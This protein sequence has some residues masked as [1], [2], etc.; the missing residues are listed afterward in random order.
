MS[1]QALMTRRPEN[2]EL[3]EIDVLAAKDEELVEISK[4]L[5]LNLSLD[6]MKSIQ[7]YFA[8]KMRKPTD[9]ELQSLGQ[10]WSEHCCYKSSKVFL[11]EHIFNIH[12][13]DVLLKGDAGVMVFAP[14]VIFGGKKIYPGTVHQVKI[15]NAIT[16]IIKGIIAS[17]S[18]IA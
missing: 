11:R 14:P 17:Q 18:A 4:A 2:F 10:A 16:I 5:S 3:S 13:P 6:E 8:A 9:I 1:I 12:N 15:G 7:R